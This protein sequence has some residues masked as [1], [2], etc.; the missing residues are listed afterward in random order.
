MYAG[1]EYHL[2]V[3]AN[4]DNGW[5]DVDYFCVD[6]ADDR[7]DMTVWYFPRNQTAW[8]SSPY[9]DILQATNN[10]DG[11]RVL[12]MDGGVLIDPFE[13]DFYLDLPIRMTWGFPGAFSLL[14]NLVLYM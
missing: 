10:Y 11:P 12:R 13:S 9:I 8:T 6:F 1:N 3:E 4:D 2:I 7:D 14:N 5:R